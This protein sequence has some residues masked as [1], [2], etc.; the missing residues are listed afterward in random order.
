ML[1]KLVVT[2]GR[3]AATSPSMSTATSFSTPELRAAPD[4]RG[5]SHSSVTALVLLVGPPDMLLH[6]YRPVNDLLTELSVDL[7]PNKFSCGAQP[8]APQE[9][10]A[11]D[12][13]EAFPGL[14]TQH[15]I[16]EI[17]GPQPA[18]AHIATAL[19]LKIMA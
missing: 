18:R 9:L 11:D 16:L 8:R 3:A 17:M 6:A 13:N 10:L 1:N 14:C 7:G 19:P 12:T 5:T 15:V 2:S 4:V